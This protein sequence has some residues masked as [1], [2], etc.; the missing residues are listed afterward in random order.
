MAHPTNYLSSPSQTTP[1]NS[2]F[3][4]KPKVDYKVS[5]EQILKT[6]PEGSHTEPQMQDSN[7]K[8]ELRWRFLNIPIN[9]QIK[10]VVEISKQE[11][12]KQREYLNKYQKWVTQTI[13]PIFDQYVTQQYYYYSNN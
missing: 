9:G 3:M 7:T 11:P 1:T 2:V 10:K 5:Y 6:I 12:N 8:I 13:D 4:K